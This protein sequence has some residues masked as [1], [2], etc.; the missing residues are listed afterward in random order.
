MKTLKI[1]NVTIYSDT[2]PL[3][4]INLV[5]YAKITLNDQ[6]SLQGFRLYIKQNKLIVTFPQDYDN[7]NQCYSICS[8]IDAKLKFNI[9]K[10]IKNTYKKEWQDDV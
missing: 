1:T 5:A 4:N 7:K 6:L 2:K 9:I 3:N 8:A 10:R